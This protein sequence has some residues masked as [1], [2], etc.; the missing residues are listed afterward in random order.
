VFRQGTD[1]GLRVELSREHTARQ[2]R[3]C[4]VLGRTVDAPE[5]VEYLDLDTMLGEAIRVV[6]GK[7]RGL[8]SVQVG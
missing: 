8:L 7:A 5:P 6:L 4:H 1:A 3:E 2:D